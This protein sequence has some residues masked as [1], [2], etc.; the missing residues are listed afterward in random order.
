MLSAT[1]LEITEED[2]AP[3]LLDAIAEAIFTALQDIVT[4]Y[5]R[6]GIAQQLVRSFVW[7]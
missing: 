7:P 1:E 3:S 6:A 4:F 2:N 5:K